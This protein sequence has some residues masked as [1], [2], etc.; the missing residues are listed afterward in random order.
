MSEA[1]VNQVTL[2]CLL[3][4]QMFSKHLKN[5]KIKSLN[6]EERKFYKKRIFNLF[7][8]ILTGNNPNNLLP[9]VKY[10][11]ENFVNSSINYF[12]II[13][14]NDLNQEE[15]KEFQI[16]NE[17]NYNTNECNEY[18][19]SHNNFNKNDE[20]D[21][22]LMRSI[23]IDNHSL[24]KYVKRKNTNAKEKI[25]MPLQKNINLQD[26]ELKLKGLNKKNNIN[27]LYE[28]SSKKNDK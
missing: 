24:D 26:P 18:L 8:E 13:D 20:A 3:N 14:S 25:I 7:K 23:K 5:Q 17:S 27:N 19:E 6:K 15:Y 22:L 16:N 9:D 12:K 10:A 28:D 21:K 2:D 4:K 11:Y 1:F